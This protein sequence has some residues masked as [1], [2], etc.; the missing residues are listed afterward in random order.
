MADGLGYSV[1][2]LVGRSFSTLLDPDFIKSRPTLWDQAQKGIKTSLYGLLTKDGDKR[3][4]EFD[5]VLHN[6]SDGPV[7]QCTARDI[8][9]QKSAESE[10]ERLISELEAK[11]AELE[12]FTYTV[13]HDLKSPLFTIRGFLG[14]LEQDALS[15]NHVRLKSDMQRVTDATDKM[16][17][18][19]N[20][21][22]ELSRI[23]LVINSPEEISL[24]KLVREA[25][26][27]H[28]D[29]AKQ[30][31]AMIDINPNMPTVLGDRLRLLEVYANLI[32]NALKF[33]SETST[34]QV[35]IS[36]EIQKGEVICWVR[37][38]GIGIALENHERVFG[39]FNK[40][41]PKTDGTGVGL[42]IV[43]RIIEGHG[44]RIWIE[45]A[46]IDRGTTVF[47]T[48]ALASK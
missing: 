41:N 35:N 40:L 31:A 29:Y 11:N 1:E 15:G 37:D 6:L 34:P 45:S 25:C 13:S 27:Q 43:K 20:D 5:I 3:F 36:A 18:L 47:F 2:E 46:G 21:L 28:E 12:R 17:R 8:T 4:F 48:L 22:L 42:A 32:E 16:L 9:T 14:Y 30:T 19:L 26:E 10:R 44:G 23:G 24:T 39:I 33:R 38:N 7:I